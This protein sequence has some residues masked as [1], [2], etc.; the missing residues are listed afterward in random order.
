MNNTVKRRKCSTL[1]M[2]DGGGKEKTVI[3]DGW[4]KD[5]VGIGWLT[6]RPATEDDYKKY[7]TVEN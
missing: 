1:L 2:G 7:P 5:Y 4:V 6:L 3:D